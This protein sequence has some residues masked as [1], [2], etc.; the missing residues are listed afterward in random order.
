MVGKISSMLSTATT[1][2]LLSSKSKNE[3]PWINKVNQITQGN[4]VVIPWKSVEI[5]NNELLEL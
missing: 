3:I 1:N 2:R 5:K 4:M